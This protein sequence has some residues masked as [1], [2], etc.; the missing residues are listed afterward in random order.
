MWPS[1]FR[2]VTA[3]VLLLISVV[4]KGSKSCKQLLEIAQAHSTD[5]CSEFCSALAVVE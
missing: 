2:L 4:N 3:N 1:R 5:A